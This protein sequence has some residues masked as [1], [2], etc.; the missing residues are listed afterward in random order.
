MMLQRQ[1]PRKGIIVPRKRSGVVLARFSRA[2]ALELHPPA[3]RAAV[4]FP[5][6][7]EARAP[8]LPSQRHPLLE[9]RLLPR[10][11][12]VPSPNHSPFRPPC[13]LPLFVGYW[14]VRLVNV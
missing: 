9:P 4:I 13:I 14:I 6:N 1:E 3:L 11:A 8:A 2:T 7:V 12:N 5:G 10:S